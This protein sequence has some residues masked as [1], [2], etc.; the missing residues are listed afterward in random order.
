MQIRGGPAAVIGDRILHDRPLLHDCNGKVAVSG[1]IRKPEDGQ[2]RSKRNTMV[3]GFGSNNAAEALFLFLGREMK[4]VLVKE[5][6]SFEYADLPTPEPAPGE[7]LVRVAVAGL[8]RTDIKLIDVG[9]RDLTLPR[10]PAE[11]VVGQVVALGSEV[12]QEWLQKR[13][14]VYPGT[15]CGTCRPCT[16]G[17]GNLCR[18][19]QIMGFHR[20]GGF[21][22]YVVAPIRSL[23]EI[24]DG[25]EFDR[26]VL[27]EPLSCCLNA[28][29]LAQLK[30]GECLGVWGGG[31]AGI[32]LARAAQAS[33]AEPII[34]EPDPYRRSLLRAE[35]LPPPGRRFDVAVVAVG[36]P[37]AYREAMDRLAPRGRLVLFSGLSRTES[38][39]TIDFNHLHYHEQSLI[40]A[41]GCSYRHGEQAIDW[42]GSG[43]VRIDDLISHRMPLAFLGRAIELVRKH[44]CMKILLYP[45]N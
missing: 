41:Y 15:S 21:A 34:I 44:H 39:R 9:H 12:G 33:G 23:I 32:L 22:E 4:A 26:A 14:Y 30:A 11:E 43:K 1:L 6:G 27:A 17:A 28:L 31:P 42:I 36:S 8:C 3:K 10:I 37:E 29:E 18:S 16:Q 24:P 40:G 5:I 38:A 7:V 2:E 35:A 20:D 25:C 45:N 13:V 19:M